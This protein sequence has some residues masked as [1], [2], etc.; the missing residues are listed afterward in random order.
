MQKIDRQVIEDIMETRM[1]AGFYADPPVD[2]NALPSSK[3]SEHRTID[4]LNTRVLFLESSIRML[5]SNLAKMNLEP[6][7][8]PTQ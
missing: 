7:L 6:L 4:Q 5:Q 8:L 1:V 3:P 2:E